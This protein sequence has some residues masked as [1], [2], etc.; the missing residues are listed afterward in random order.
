MKDFVRRIEELR[1]GVIS[2][3]R[4]LNNKQGVLRAFDKHHSYKIPHDCRTT[5]SPSGD[6]KLYIDDV[7]DHVIT[8]RSSLKQF[9]GLLA[10]SQN[11]YLA[12]LDID[13]L[14]YRRKVNTFI[15]RV[16]VISLILTLLNVLCGLFSTNVNANVPLYA[17]N[18]VKTWLIIVSGEVVAFILLV[19]LAKR[20]RW[21]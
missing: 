11:N 9:E 19:L 2:L 1:K 14:A 18:N 10:R 6:I 20:C 7:Q 21:I 4:L 3:T 13:N 16:T 8:M 17:D 5:I 15:S 12:Q